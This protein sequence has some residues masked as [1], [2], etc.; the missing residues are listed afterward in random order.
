MMY[1]RGFYT[2]VFMFIPL[3]LCAQGRVTISGDITDRKTGETLIGAVVKTDERH[4][5][6]SNEFG[7]YS[8]TVPSGRLHLSVSAMGYK[9]YEAD[10]LLNRDSVIS[11]QLDEDVQE[12]QQV[13]IHSEEKGGDNTRQLI[14]SEKLDLETFQKLP[15][16]FG[17]R[18]VFKMIQLLPGVQPA[19]EG[20]SGFYVRGGTT[21]QNLIV[22][23][24][25]VV[26]NPSHL[27]GFVS[28][29]NSDVIKDATL[30]KGNAPANFGGRLSSVLD[31][32]M[33]DGDK[34]NYHVAGGISPVSSRI[35]VDGPLMKGKSS[36]NLSARR[37]F[38]D[39]FTRLSND[40]RINSSV[41]Y[42][43]DLNARLNFEIS[44]KYR[45]YISGYYGEDELG[46]DGFRLKWHN[47]V[48]S[49]RLNAKIRPDLY[50]N[51]SFTFTDYMSVIRISSDETDVKL[52]SEIMD[53]TLKQ[54]FLF[55]P[56]PLH[57]IRA[58]YNTIVHYI[59][60]GEL[61]GSGTPSLG[62]A[63]MSRRLAWENAVYVNDDWKIASWLNMNAGLRL[64]N[65]NSC[66][67]GNY[68]V[69]G[70]DGTMDTLSAATGRF[71]ASYFN[72]EPRLGLNFIP[73][74]NVAIKLGYARHTQFIHLLSNAT[75][76]NPTDK[77]I[78]SS[79]IVRPEISDQVSLGYSHVF[80]NGMFEVNLE[81]YFKY[82][83]NQIDYKTGADVLNN[84]LYEADLLFGNG[85]AYGAEFL[86]RKLKGNITGW[87]SYTLSRSERRIDQINDGTWYPARQDRTHDLNIVLMYH[88]KR[89]T[90]SG[91]F[92]YYTG[93]A[94]TF[95]S[96]KYEIDGKVV[97]MYTERN[98]YRMPDYHRLDLGVT[99]DVRSKRVKLNKKGEPRRKMLISELGFGAYNVYN[100]YNTYRI[101]FRKSDADPDK[102][103]AVS[104]ALFGIVPYVSWSFKF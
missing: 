57:T 55:Y 85:R 60:P 37:T 47:G 11:V 62:V 63:D 33:L 22:L 7:S 49:L 28:T 64:V 92:V 20:S 76:G 84:E 16:L 34:Y 99:V 52:Q 50:S 70:S 74:K 103:E 38:V 18:D 41:L 65:F 6:S 26:Y 25:A 27:L 32:R 71:Y 19:S 9:V 43:Y 81:G 68:Y 12:L 66:G 72:A 96:G 89:W 13:V 2:V 51:T 24:D 97:W 93:N 23:D 8:L 40:K 54:E 58:G 80:Y 10:L 86:F 67:P 61:D 95:P 53:F 14:G 69:P 83:Q 56:S 88:Y 98:G 30:Y 5:V 4:I 31:I 17:E 87:V 104:T 94:V 102:T 1:Y 36:F 48:A 3:W 59:T 73:A 44:Q 79:N 42:F 77:W 90:F 35:G 82:M 46:L 78:A 100:R 39:L 21:D 15:V 45:L 29:F 75:A 101:T 91:T